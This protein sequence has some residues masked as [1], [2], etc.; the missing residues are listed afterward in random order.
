MRSVGQSAQPLCEEIDKFPL[1]RIANVRQ[2]WAA[3]MVAVVLSASSG[4]AMATSPPSLVVQ[5]QLEQT[6]VSVDFDDVSLGKIIQQLRTEHNLNI[7][8]NE[9]ALA[10]EGVDLSTP[11][12][13]R[14][15]QVPLATVLRL[16]L[17]DASN[18]EAMLSYVV[19][20]EV[21]V[22]STETD[23]TA[24]LVLRTYDVSDL[25]DSGYARRRMMNTPLLRLHLTGSEL[26]GA[27]IGGTSAQQNPFQGGGG[28]GEPAG[29]G[30]Q[31]GG[32]FERLQDVIELIMATVDTGSWRVHGGGNG[33]IDRQGNRLVV[34]AS[35]VVHRKLQDL[36][37]LLR[38]EPPATI[39]LHIALIQVA[40]STLDKL[41]EKLAPDWP[42]MT[43][44]AAAAKIETELAAE[45]AALLRMTT[46]GPSGRAQIISSLRQR[47]YVAQLQ[48]VVDE[49]SETY[50]PEISQANS[51]IELI[52]LP[53]LSPDRT[54]LSLDVSLALATLEH[55]ADHVF[56]HGAGGEKLGVQLRSVGMQTLISRVR[57]DPKHAILLVVPPADVF[58][59]E[60]A[61]AVFL[62]IRPSVR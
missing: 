39:D 53:V 58:C 20:D 43:S 54:F 10:K 49:A 38:S 27:E 13:L 15:N 17:R 8:V 46:T 26:Q 52:I 3:L 41:R 61:E 7:Y 21:I 32:T 33:F 30:I 22:I 37:D 48:P 56:V 28:G 40:P 14:L 60:S 4:C 57:F 29:S 59:G 47:D 2:L 24:R 23:T 19:E 25:L 18:G 36:L 31:D 42:R 6:T 5:E 12:T 51:G 55:L 45:G 44:A 62:L 11:I 35:P 9:R 16:L 34:T 50:Q 1:F